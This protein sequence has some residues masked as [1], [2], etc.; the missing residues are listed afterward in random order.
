[1][2]IK[3]HSTVQRKSG[4][5]KHEN[6]IKNLW[7]YLCLLFKLS[8]LR[9]ALLCGRTD[10]TVIIISFYFILF[11]PDTTSITYDFARLHVVTLTDLKTKIRWL[12]KLLRCIKHEGKVYLV[13][14][15]LSTYMRY[16]FRKLIPLKTMTVTRATLSAPCSAFSPPP[17][18]P[19]LLLHNTLA[20]C[21]WQ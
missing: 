14:F 16:D 11:P 6:K 7:K 18:P 17:P 8:W 3:R 2:S 20:I 19:P 4:W 12:F 1:M 9:S 21:L 15:S 5:K 10:C 13:F